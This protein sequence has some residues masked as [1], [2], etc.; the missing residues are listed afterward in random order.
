MRQSAFR[1]SSFILA[2]SAFGSFAQDTLDFEA[3]DI[4]GTPSVFKKVGL[5]DGDFQE[6]YN[7]RGY[8]Q[9]SLFENSLADFWTSEGEMCVK[10][11]L[12]EDDLANN[13]RL[14]WN[15]DQDGCDWVG[16]G[17]GWDGW[18]SKDM[19]YVI[20]TLALELTVRSL[21]KPFTNLPWAFCFEDY[22]GSQAWLGYNRSFLKADAITSEWTKVLMP[23]QLFPFE[24]NDVDASNIKQLLIQLFSEGEIEIKSIE[25]VPFSGKL[26]Q[27]VTATQS[28]SSVNIDGSLAEWS[29]D[30][31]EFSEGQKFAVNYTADSLFFAFNI[32]DE[33]PQQNT[34]KGGDLWQGDAIEIAFSTNP[35]ADPKRSFLLLS[36]QHIGINCGANPYVWDWKKDSEVTSANHKITATTNGYILE[37]A[38]PTSAFYQFNPK[39]G[40]ELDIEIAIDLGT[41]AGRDQQLHWNSGLDEG[42]HLSPAKWGVLILQ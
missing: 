39:A 33:T 18:T 29:N 42:F 1:I 8:T 10:G 41:T 28:K 6:E 30:F 14:K 23:L 12:V 16:I 7:V 25:L 22:S 32:V 36:D 35:T 20:D 26:K 31:I 11:K 19:G 24:E 38:V 17:L 4:T 3:I 5:Y 2:F 21:D 15:K 13:L 34:R 27:E 40:T 37:L 9:F